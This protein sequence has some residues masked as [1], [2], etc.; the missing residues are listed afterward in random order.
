MHSRNIENCTHRDYN[1]SPVF[2]GP[3]Y[4]KRHVEFSTILDLKGTPLSFF[5]KNF[6]WFLA[7][8]N[9]KLRWL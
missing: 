2:K 7:E 6:Y 4:E 3:S 9:K 1:L 8:V 5:Q